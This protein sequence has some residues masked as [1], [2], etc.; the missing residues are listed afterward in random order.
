[1]VVSSHG[2]PIRFFPDTVHEQN[3]VEPLIDLR[4]LSDTEEGAVRTRGQQHQ[5]FARFVINDKSAHWF[6]ADQ[7]AVTDFQIFTSAMSG[8]R[9]V[10]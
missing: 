5:A 10:P 9:L 4:V 2:R 7:H 1:M 8:D 3:C 6:L